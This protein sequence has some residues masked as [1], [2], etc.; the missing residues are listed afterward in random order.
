MTFGRYESSTSGRRA[1]ETKIRG[2]RRD[3]YDDDRV[4]LEKCSPMG[5]RTM[6]ASMKLV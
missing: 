4:V 1:L 6:R 2:A 3:G 5:P